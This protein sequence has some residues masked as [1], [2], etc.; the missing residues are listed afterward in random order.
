MY[1][2]SF[3]FAHAGD[4]PGFLAAFGTTN[5]GSFCLES[6]AALCLSSCQQAYDVQGWNLACMQHV[7]LLPSR[8][9]EWVSSCEDANTYKMQSSWYRFGH[10]SARLHPCMT[11][12][13]C[14]AA[15]PLPNML[16]MSLAVGINSFASKSS[17]LS[18]V[19]CLLCC[20]CNH[21][22]PSHCGFELC[23]IANAVLTLLMSRVVWVPCLWLILP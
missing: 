10:Q 16:T 20:S 15:P 9:F 12:E 4:I 13:P 5:F 1:T 14:S 8:A 23:C 3:R 2:T 7:L 21:L 18:T 11:A 6:S 17:L 22:F 19:A